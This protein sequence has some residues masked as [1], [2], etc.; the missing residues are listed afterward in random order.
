M[1]IP[2]FYARMLN[3]IIHTGIFFG[4]VVSNHFELG[5][6][7][8]S[9]CHDCYCDRNPGNDCPPEC[10]ATPG[11]NA[12]RDEQSGD[13]FVHNSPFYTF[14][15]VEPA[16]NPI[17][18]AKV[19]CLPP[20]AFIDTPPF[21]I[22]RVKDDSEVVTKNYIP[23]EIEDEYLPCAECGVHIPKDSTNKFLCGECAEEL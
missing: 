11:L 16:E 21:K 8:T 20:E 17:R 14:V 22:F 10:H 9:P 4:S 3:P 15:H 13:V 12:S 7:P 6:V 19:Y 23:P 5:L 18:Q 2:Y 1:P